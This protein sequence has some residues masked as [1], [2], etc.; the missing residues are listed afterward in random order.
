[1]LVSFISIS[2]NKP[3]LK[4]HNGA[5]IKRRWAGGWT[6]TTATSKQKKSCAGLQTSAQFRT[7]WALM[8]ALRS[9]ITQGGRI[10]V[11]GVSLGAGCPGR[12]RFSWHCTS[13]KWALTGVLQRSTGSPHLHWL[14]SGRCG[15][16]WDRITDTEIFTFALC[17]TNR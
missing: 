8:A 16:L 10:K 14:P 6:K 4:W 9:A 12:R 17:T 1:M 3:P 7:Q 5:D 11:A 15:R 2:F 13:G